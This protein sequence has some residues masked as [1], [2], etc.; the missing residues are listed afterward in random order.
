MATQ[1]QYLGNP[2]LKKAHT[3]SRFTKKHEMDCWEKSTAQNYHFGWLL[4][5][6]HRAPFMQP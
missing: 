1:D 2:N 4:D 5:L 3:P 6:F